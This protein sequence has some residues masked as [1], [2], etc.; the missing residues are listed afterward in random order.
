MTIIS[1][2]GKLVA[3]LRRKDIS[4]LGELY[5]K[6]RVKVFQTAYAI[7][8]DHQASEDILQETF[9]KVYAKADQLD[10]EPTLA[11][12]LYRVAVNASYIWVTRH[13]KRWAPLEEMLDQILA[14]SRQMPEQQ[15]E[16]RD[17]R[18][19][20]LQALDTLDFNHRAVVVLFYVNSLSLKE[21]ANI[22]DVP[23][24]T[25]KSRLH[26]GR[27]ALRQKLGDIPA[28]NQSLRGLGFDFP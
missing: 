12:W 19:Q 8:R 25:V 10:L 24:G 28:P 18:D 4:A 22:L 16:V 20:V 21:I 6:Y 3:R 11:P 1:E 9:L 13:V 7:T 27:E 15:I 17:I 5:D 26:Y 14:P 2:D 23:L